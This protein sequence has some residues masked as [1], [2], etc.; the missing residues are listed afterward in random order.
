MKRN[1]AAEI[2]ICIHNDGALDASLFL[3]YMCYI[4]LWDLFL[5]LKCSFSPL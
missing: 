4:F 3:L 1:F 5:L 2:G